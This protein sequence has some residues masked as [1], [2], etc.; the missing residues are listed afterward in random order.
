MSMEKATAAND[1]QCSNCT[2]AHHNMAGQ[3]GEG[4]CCL[5]RNRMGGCSQKKVQPG[6]TKLAGIS[7]VR[8]IGREPRQTIKAGSK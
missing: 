3:F 6:A 7:K 1:P 2:Y 8:L 4:W 5:F